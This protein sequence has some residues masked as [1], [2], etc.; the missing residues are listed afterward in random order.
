ML[1][2]GTALARSTALGFEPETTLGPIDLVVFAGA[3]LGRTVAVLPVGTV[4]DVVRDLDFARVEAGF[5]DLVFGA[6]PLV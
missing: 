4:A 5:S 6:V 1:F 2:L 3:A